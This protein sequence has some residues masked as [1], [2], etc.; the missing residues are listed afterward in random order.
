MNK[1]KRIGYMIFLT[2]AWDI[3]DNLFG[4]IEIYHFLEGL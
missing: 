2:I 4:V 3:F 1:I